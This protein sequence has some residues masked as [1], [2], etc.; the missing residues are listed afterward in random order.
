MQYALVAE[1]HGLGKRMHAPMLYALTTYNVQRITD[2][3]QEQLLLLRERNP[4]SA[5]ALSHYLLLL[6][7]LLLL[8]QQAT[9]LRA[10]LAPVVASVQAAIYA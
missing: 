2:S 9:T 1:P 10:L 8:L 7:L 6:L 5:V 4:L 3:T